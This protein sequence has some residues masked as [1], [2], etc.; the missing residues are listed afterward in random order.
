MRRGRII[1]VFLPAVAAIIVCF[2]I[3][4]A[5]PANLRAVPSLALDERWDTNI[6]NASDNE[7]SDF[8]FR[9]SPRLTLSLDVFRTT[10]NLGGGFDLERYAKHSELDR[11]AASKY[12]DLTPAEPLRITPRF[13][14]R[15]SAR[16]VETLDAVRRNVLTQVPEPGLPPSE[17]L[18]TVRTKVRET[19]GSLQLVYLLTPNVDLGIGGGGVRREFIEG[20]PG[21]V[22]SR[23]LTGNASI[24]YRVTPRFSSGFFFDT[25]YNSFDGMPNSRTYSSGFSGSYRLTE[26]YTVDARAGATYL[27]ES[28]G[29]GDQTSHTWTPNGRLS[30]TYASADSRATLSG[31]HELAGA[32]STGTTTRRTSA[33]ISLTDRFA[34]NWWWDLSGSYQ[35]N[36]STDSSVTENVATADGTAGIRFQAAEW[37]SFRLSGSTLRQWARDSRVGG[38]VARSSVLLGVSLSNTYSIF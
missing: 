5:E 8:V 6:F 12:F 14:M 35:T 20:A 10:I 15:P 1:R 16:L 26:Q 23:S 22:N 34:L 27:R 24:T 3:S 4:S 19:S 11:N 25:S 13:S 32:G 38:D 21:L 17:A 9:A 28:T 29:A 7:V 37:V 31:S 36:R 33:R 18:V 30:L 2:A